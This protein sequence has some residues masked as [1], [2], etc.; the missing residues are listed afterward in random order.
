M[1]R[2]FQKN[3]YLLLFRQLWMI[4]LL[5]ASTFSTFLY[6]EAVNQ[7]NEFQLWAGIFIEKKISKEWSG[8]LETEYR[9][10]DGASRLFE[11]Y[12][13]TRLQYTLCPCLIVAPGY[14]QIFSELD[15]QTSWKPVYDPLIDVE[16][17]RPIQGWHFSDRS[18]FQYFFRSWAED[19]WHYRHRIQLI[20]PWKLG[21]MQWQLYGSNEFFI[22]K[23]RGY[24]Q[25][26]LI[27]GGMFPILKESSENKIKGRLFYMLR[28]EITQEH[29][30]HQHVLG[31]YGD[32]FY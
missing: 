4:V 1:Q 12:L 13:Q 19:Y 31:L 24:S 18:R 3:L 23:E 29:W 28:H 21:R 15:D 6:G 22:R 16:W 9:Y 30:H 7:N 11:Y 5:G 32:F 26:R 14:R 20:S 8:F 2:V 27:I 10:G 17:F 25:N